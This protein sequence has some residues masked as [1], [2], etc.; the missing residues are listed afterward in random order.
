VQIHANN[1]NPQCYYRVMLLIMNL[2]FDFCTHKFKNTTLMI[3]C[4]Q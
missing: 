1:N 4:N 3:Y 2:I